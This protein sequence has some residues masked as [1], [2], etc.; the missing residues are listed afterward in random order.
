MVILQNQNTSTLS[1]QFLNALQIIFFFL[2]YRLL[3]Q[4]SRKSFAGKPVS[5]GQAIL[6]DHHAIP[7]G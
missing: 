4:I 5:S 2:I 6:N 1:S 3:G 7:D